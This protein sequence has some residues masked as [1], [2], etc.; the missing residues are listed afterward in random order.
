M[1]YSVKLVNDYGQPLY[2][3]VWTGNRP[4][5][6]A[7]NTKRFSGNLEPG[8]FFDPNNDD[9]IVWYARSKDPGNPGSGLGTWHTFSPN[10]DNT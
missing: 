9:P 2:A 4:D 5:N 8:Q 6:A 1:G 10:A 7:N 3:E